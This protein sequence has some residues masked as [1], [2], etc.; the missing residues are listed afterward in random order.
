[1]N[2]GRNSARVGALGVG[3]GEDVGDAVIGGAGSKT[4]ALAGGRGEVI[5]AAG[6]VVGTGTWRPPV[7]I[8]PRRDPN[9]RAYVGFVRLRLEADQ[10]AARAA[11]HQE[12]RALLASVGPDRGLIARYRRWLG[13][14]HVIDS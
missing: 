1:M 5:E 11:G 2:S 7:A 3:V 8:D 9:L 6:A 14:P 12:L 10:E 13:L 4:G